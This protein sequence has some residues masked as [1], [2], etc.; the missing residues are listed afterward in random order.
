MQFKKI[1]NN[2]RPKFKLSF[3][4]KNPIK[5]YSFDKNKNVI[6]AIHALLKKKNKYI[7][8]ATCVAIKKT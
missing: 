6:A 1:K 3:K 2:Q 4:E 5:M 8:L 7:G